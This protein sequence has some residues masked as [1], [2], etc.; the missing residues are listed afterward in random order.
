MGPLSFRQD[1]S[2]QFFGP[3]PF[4]VG[5]RKSPGSGQFR[6]ATTGLGGILK[7]WDSEAAVGVPVG[8]PVR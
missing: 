5:W 1:F 7:I 4:S 3:A 8:V 6:F 2:F